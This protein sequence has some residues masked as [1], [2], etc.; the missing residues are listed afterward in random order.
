MPDCPPAA[1]FSDFEK[2]FRHAEHLLDERHVEE[3]AREAL[4]TVMVLLAF[5]EGARLAGLEVT[6]EEREL[7][8]VFEKLEAKRPKP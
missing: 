3:H 6:E 4:Q 8:A 5:L 2:L 1:C 7:Q